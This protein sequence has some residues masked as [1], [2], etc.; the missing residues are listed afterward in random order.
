MRAFTV[1]KGGLLNKIGTQREG[2]PELNRQAYMDA[3][4]VCQAIA[5]EQLIIDKAALLADAKPL[6]LVD[7]QMFKAIAKPMANAAQA[8]SPEAV[9]ARVND[10]ASAWR[11]KDYDN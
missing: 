2:L 9:T 11:H 10:W 4:N 5:P 6:A 1:R 8:C 7:K 3:A